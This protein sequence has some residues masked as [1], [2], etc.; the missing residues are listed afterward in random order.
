LGIP[1]RYT[2]EQLAYIIKKAW[3]FDAQKALVE[4]IATL[5]YSSARRRTGINASDHR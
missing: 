1:V 2:L 5:G 4:A 3:E